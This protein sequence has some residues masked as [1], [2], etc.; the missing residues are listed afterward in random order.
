MFRKL[1][2][3]PYMG[4]KSGAWIVRLSVIG[5][6][7]LMCLF[8]VPPDVHAISDSRWIGGVYG[9]VELWGIGY[10]RPYTRSSH[11]LTVS[12]ESRFLAR[13]DYEFK[14]AILETGDENTKV[15]RDLRLR[16]G[17]VYMEPSYGRRLNLNR[18][19]ALEPGD[20][21]TLSAY[22]R[23][24]IRARGARDGWKVEIKRKFRK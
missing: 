23:V 16:A 8:T 15:R 20:R 11:Y 5:L 6:L 21:F 7:A 13:Y 18:I 4:T 10:S 2:S 12:N 1:F 3:S 19:P 14:H 24:A 22:T 17:G 9:S